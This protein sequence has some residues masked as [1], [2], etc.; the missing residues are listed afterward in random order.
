MLLQ[1]VKHAPADVLEK[2]A[3]LVTSGERGPMQSLLDPVGF[4]SD[5]FLASDFE[6][7][8]VSGETDH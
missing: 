8:E 1:I 3:V 5:D 6:R 2:R 4:V 7:G